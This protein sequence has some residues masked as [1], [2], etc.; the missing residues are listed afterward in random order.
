M[1]PVGSAHFLVV[2]LLQGGLGSSR[3]GKCLMQH[4]V[5]YCAYRSRCSQATQERWWPLTRGPA[6][7]P[8]SNLVGLNLTRCAQILHATQESGIPVPPHIRATFGSLHATIEALEGG[9]SA[10]AIAWARQER[11]FLRARGSPLEYLLHRS[12]FVRI[13]TG[14]SAD[15]DDDE[16]STTEAMAVAEE[17]RKHSMAVDGGSAPR[18]GAT[19]ME[20]NGAR[21]MGT[22]VE[23]ALIYGRKNFRPF[24]SEHLSEIQRLFALLLFLPALPPSSDGVPLTPPDLGTLAAGVPKPYRGLLDES[25]IHACALVPILR[26]EFCARAGVAREPPLRVGVEVGAGGALSRI[27]KVREIMKERGNEWSQADELPV[28]SMAR[29]RP[30]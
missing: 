6:C 17:A 8:L 19:A 23:R 2:N 15:V 7:F 14:A 5:L 27:V 24:L 11:E 28:S 13:A 1:F 22:N 30:R 9:R 20:A 26:G 16:D 29:T 4:L 10:P 21:Q 25:A 18:A 12:Q 3:D